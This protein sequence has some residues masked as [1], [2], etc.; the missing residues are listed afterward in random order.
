ML[1]EQILFKY[2]QTE[3]LDL[4]ERVNVELNDQSPQLIKLILE[5]LLDLYISII[6]W[7]ILCRDKELYQLLDLTVLHVLQTLLH[8]VFK[9]V[10]RLPVQLRKVDTGVLIDGVACIATR[11]KVFVSIL[12]LTIILLKHL[13]ALL[14]AQ[15]RSQ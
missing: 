15:S 1:H 5:P 2:G 14:Y 7:H 8:L 11:R 13:P 9:L 4:R 3:S 6:V 10:A 12:I